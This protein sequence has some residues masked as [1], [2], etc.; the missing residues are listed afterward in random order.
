MIRQCEFKRRYDPELG[1]YQRRHQQF[2]RNAEP[3]EV[4]RRE[5]RIDSHEVNRETRGAG[6][7]EV[8]NSEVEEI[9][10]LPSETP[11]VEK[12][13][14]DEIVRLLRSRKNNVCEVK[15]STN[16]DSIDFK[17]QEWVKRFLE[18]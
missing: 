7:D 10:P 17:I 4:E 1:R 11:R 2:E 8:L 12:K 15:Q 13:G 16:E 14:G 6:V 3:R 9:T 18:K 5:E